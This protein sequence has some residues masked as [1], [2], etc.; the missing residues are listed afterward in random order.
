MAL[1]LLA[2]KTAVRAVGLVRKE[3]KPKLLMSWGNVPPARHMEAK[4]KQDD[5]AAAESNAWLH[6]GMGDG[7]PTRNFDFGSVKAMAQ[8]VSSHYI[9]FSNEL[10]NVIKIDFFFF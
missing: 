10:G 7:K 3:R 1:P 9:H 2:A 5:T 8:T 4:F 6:F